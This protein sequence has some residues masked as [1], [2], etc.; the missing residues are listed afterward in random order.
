V[1]AAGLFAVALSS[2]PA[3]AHRAEVEAWRLRRLQ[4]LSRSDGWLTLAGLFWLDEGANP[5]GSDKAN[6]IV[7]PAPTPPCMGELVLEHGSVRVRVTRGVELTS[8]GKPVTDMALKTDAESDPTVLEYGPV[9]FYVIKRRDR[10]GI[11]VKNAQSPALLHFTGLDSFPISED[12]RFDA[13]FEPYD[14]PRDVV[15]P[16][17]M[18]G[19]DV[20]KCPGAVVFQVGG[21]DYRLE[22]VIEQGSEDLFII[23]GDKTNGHETYGAG[24]FVYVKWPDARGWT[25]LDFNKAYNPPCVFTPY[26]TCPLPP[27][28]NRLPIC[29][30]AGEK[31]YGDH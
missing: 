21:K 8:D 17:V 27:A 12:W 6:R 28:A 18:G 5:F 26:A 4:R 15:V 16:N 22:P 23:F 2:T 29:I 13:R 3:D 9:G 25:V 14:P 31:T 7:L 11:R 30:E 10:Y 24:R 1:I 20:E 19:T